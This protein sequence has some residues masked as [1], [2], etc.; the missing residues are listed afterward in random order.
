MNV[1]YDTLKDAVVTWRKNGHI[2]EGDRYK[3]S[4]NKG[5]LVILNTEPKDE[6]DYMVKIDSDETQ[7]F[8][9]KLQIP[10]KNISKQIIHHSTP[11]QYVLQKKKEKKKD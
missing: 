9:F 8:D 2:I 3:F 6:G 4:D 10:G 7:I 5:T 11:T 1:T